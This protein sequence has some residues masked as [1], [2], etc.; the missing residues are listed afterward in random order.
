MLHAIIPLGLAVISSSLIISND[1]AQPITPHFDSG[2]RLTPAQPQETRPI[3]QDPILFHQDEEVS[4]LNTQNDIEQQ[5]NRALLE[6]NWTQLNK[7]LIYYQQYTHHDPILLHYA[8]GA[9]YRSQGQHAQAIN[10][11]RAIISI[12]PD[13]TYVRMD[14]A[15]MLYENKEYI[16]SEDQ[17]RKVQADPLAP[18][19]HQITSQY[20]SAI[21]KKQQWKFDA[22][23]N[24]TRNDNINNASEIKQFEL[25]GYQ[26]TKTPESLPQSGTG[27]SYSFRIEKDFNLSGNHY[28]NTKTQLYG[29]HYW[30][31]NDYSER[32]L[33]LSA[34]YKNQSI[35]SWFEL[36]PFIEKTWLG[37]PSYGL[38][39]GIT[40]EYGRWSSPNW[41]WIGSY[42]FANKG[43]DDPRLNRYEGNLHAFSATVAHFLSSNFLLFAGVDALYENLNAKDES[44][45]RNGIHIG[46]VKEWGNGL[47]SRVN[48][49][50]SRRSF[51]EPHFFFS[52]TR[53]DNEFSSNFALWHR[54]IHFYGVTPKINFRY[55]KINSNI[56]AFYSRTNKQWF[57]S[58]E[59]SF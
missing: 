34:G 1:H 50:Y 6:K 28:L 13:L 51:D 38:N 5:I 7:L 9:Y 24:Y 2:E 4:S 40:T 35:N 47:S 56:P 37:S 43:Y 14:L 53:K 52:K 46:A 27:L 39:K 18:A 16:A 21:Q 49:R 31:N 10:E 55:Q 22:S 54:N 48:L 59:K 33:R 15:A 58:F 36:S 17:F 42:T 32:T 20:L 23:I 29:V 57:L 26:F 25:N 19:A 45:R 3:I 44:S 12:R 41:Q 8:R 30:N 11:Y